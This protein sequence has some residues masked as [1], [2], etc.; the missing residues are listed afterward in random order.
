MTEIRTGAV[1][2]SLFVVLLAGASLAAC[3]SPQYAV[4]GP[5]ITPGQ[6]PNGAGG[7]YK[8]G[9]PYQV[10]GVWYVPKEEPNYD[11]QG[12]ASWYGQDFHQK[13]TANGEIFD[14]RMPSAAHPTLP[15]PSIVEVTNLDNGR[16]IQ[17]RVNDRGPFVGGRII[18]LS[19]EGARQLGYDRTGTA[20]VRVRYVGPAPLGAPDAGLRYAEYT[21]TPAPSAIPA[22]PMPYQGLTP[23]APVSVTSAPLAPIQ[24]SNPAP[25]TSGGFQT[26]SNASSYRVQAGAFSDHERARIVA[27]R[28]SGTALATIEPTQRADGVT[29]YR[30]MVA[31]GPDE[32]AAWG[33][34][35]RVAELGFADARVIRPF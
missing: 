1:A 6:A 12:V 19:Q 28:L 14:M 3:A 7:R 15:L 2:R 26:A 24:V 20:N 13:A 18:D 33:V 16:K 9:E 5:A 8:V 32:A 27:D 17:V 31:G 30:V 10:A 34:R 21:P 35:D 23:P 22:A 29:L 25:V 11:Q 4:R